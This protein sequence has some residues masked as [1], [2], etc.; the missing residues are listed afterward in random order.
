MN[1][2]ANTILGAVTCGAKM[3][4]PKPSEFELGMLKGQLMAARLIGPA[5]PAL[6]DEATAAVDAISGTNAPS[7]HQRPAMP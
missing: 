1:I 3:F 5:D 2:N 6:L 4:G 7:V